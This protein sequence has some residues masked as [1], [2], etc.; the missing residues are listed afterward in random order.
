VRKVYVSFISVIFGDSRNIF[1]LLLYIFRAI[2]QHK[3]CHFQIVAQ[4]LLFIAS[5]CFTTEHDN[6]QEATNFLDV[7]IAVYAI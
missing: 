5:T 3:N 4:Y 7:G 1:C 6:L 2:V